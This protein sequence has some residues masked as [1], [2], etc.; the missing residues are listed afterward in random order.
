MPLTEPD[1]KKKF[2]QKLF[3]C[4]FQ[5]EYRTFC[6]LYGTI[7]S[8]KILRLFLDLKIQFFV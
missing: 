4:S 3:Y 7:R 5:T 8:I 2:F 6:R 1:Q